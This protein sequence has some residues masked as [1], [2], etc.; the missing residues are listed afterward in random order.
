MLISTG[1]QFPCVR[2]NCWNRTAYSFP[3]RKSIWFEIWHLWSDERN[4]YFSTRF[5]KSESHNDFFFWFSVMF[6][7]TSSSFF[8]NRFFLFFN[9]WYINLLSQRFVRR[10]FDSRVHLSQNFFCLRSER[11]L[12]QLQDVYQSTERSGLNDISMGDFLL[13]ASTYLVLLNYW[14]NSMWRFGASVLSSLQC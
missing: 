9:M 5:L 6:L 1:N 10:W 14:Y 4:P 8:S 3:T 2:K 12:F 13:Y 7:S 11:Y